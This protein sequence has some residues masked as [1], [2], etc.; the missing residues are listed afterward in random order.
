MQQ[1]LISL[2][3]SDVVLMGKNIMMRKV[4]KSY[5]KRSPAV[6]KVLSHSKA[7]IGFVFTRQDLVEVRD[8]LGKQV[9]Q[10]YDSGTIFSPEILDIKPVDL[11]DKF[12]AG[13]AN[14]AALCLLINYPTTAAAPAAAAAAPAATSEVSRRKKRMRNLKV[15]LEIW[16]LL[17]STKT[18]LKNNTCCFLIISVHH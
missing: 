15:K 18:Q 3:G 1:I 7:N 11:R 12:L 9:E 13:V 5:L 8:R 6:E 2:G 16:V 4:I 17:F 14:I 10:V